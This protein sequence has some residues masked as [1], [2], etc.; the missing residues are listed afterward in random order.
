[1]EALLEPSRHVRSGWRAE[2][3]WRLPTARWHNPDA[4]A[5]G[6]APGRKKRKVQ[7]LIL[8]S[9]GVFLSLPLPS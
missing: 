8:P 7:W 4:V 1:M 9:K 6:I 3:G 2:E 5:I